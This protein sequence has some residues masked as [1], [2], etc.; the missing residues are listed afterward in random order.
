MVRPSLAIRTTPKELSLQRSGLV[1]GVCSTRHQAS[2]KY[3]VMASSRQVS[4]LHQSEAPTT[5]NPLH[6]GWKTFPML[7]KTTIC[8]CEY[9]NTQ[10]AATV[11]FEV[12]FQTCR[13]V[14]SPNGSL[15]KTSSKKRQTIKCH[16][17]TTT[18]WQLGAS[19]H[20]EGR[21]Y[22]SDKLRLDPLVLCKTVTPQALNSSVSN[23]NT[24]TFTLEA[25]VTQF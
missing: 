24:V 19:F 9:S 23:A 25:A 3:F 6:E 11:Y 18:L 1:S 10:L 8:L 21:Q 5:V 4:S 22:V 2:P 7:R 17:G 16:K 20:A 13:M 15:T 12:T 14:P